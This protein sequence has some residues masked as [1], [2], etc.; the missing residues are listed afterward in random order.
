MIMLLIVASLFDINF[1]LYVSNDSSNDCELLLIIM[2]QDSMQ[3]KLFA[4]G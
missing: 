1:E 3:F 4:G 2:L